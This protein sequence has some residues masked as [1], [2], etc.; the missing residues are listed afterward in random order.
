[1][2]FELIELGRATGQRSLVKFAQAEGLG[3]RLPFSSVTSHC[4][5]LSFHFL[6][7]VS[8]CDLISVC[9]VK[10]VAHMTLYDCHLTLFP[11][12]MSI[13]WI[14]PDLYVHV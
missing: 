1:M 3:M 5:C 9:M 7:T 14:P 13:W 8:G 4:I 2:I 11:C 12:H 6:K 10:H